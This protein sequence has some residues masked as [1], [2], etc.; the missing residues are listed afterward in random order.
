MVN[1]RIQI[2]LKAIATEIAVANIIAFTSGDI[3][4]TAYAAGAG[5]TAFEF[6]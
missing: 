2:T 5:I 3:T 6:F 1:Q 4:A